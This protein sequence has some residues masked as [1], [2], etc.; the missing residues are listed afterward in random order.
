MVIQKKEKYITNLFVKQAMTR[1][2]PEL[3]SGY[4]KADLHERKTGY[5]CV[6]FAR[7]CCCEGPNCRYFHRV[8]SLEECENVD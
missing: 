6:H 7:G 4:T 2:D 3:D 1:C 8:P 5:F